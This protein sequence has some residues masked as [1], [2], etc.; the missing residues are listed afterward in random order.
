SA[1]RA[2]RTR[3]GSAA[4]TLREGMISDLLERLSK[5]EYPVELSLRPDWIPRAFKE[6]IEHGYMHVKFTGTRGGTELGVPID[7]ERSDLTHLNFEEATGRATV[8]S[9]LTLDF[10]RMRCSATGSSPR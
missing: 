3:H 4:L 1:A 7:F 6:C 8:V 9:A 2:A 5:G 10:V